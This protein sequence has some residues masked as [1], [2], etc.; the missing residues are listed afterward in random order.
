MLFDAATKATDKKYLEVWNDSSG[1]KLECVLSKFLANAT[2]RVLE[3]DI[4]SARL[5]SCSACF[6]EEYIPASM[7][8]KATIDMTNTIE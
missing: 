7:G 5:E 1:S 8:I 6:L 3:G 2:Q 4:K